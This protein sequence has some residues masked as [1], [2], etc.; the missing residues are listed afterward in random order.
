ML[1]NKVLDNHPIC[2]VVNKLFEKSRLFTNLAQHFADMFF[3]NGNQKAAGNWMF[4]F[5]V[6][7]LTWKTI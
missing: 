4:L 2:M 3:K 7:Y 5:G 1:L 6:G